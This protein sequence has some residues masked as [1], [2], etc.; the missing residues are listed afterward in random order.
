MSAAAQTALAAAAEDHWRVLPAVAFA[1][2]VGAVSV[3][4]GVLDY[5]M[6]R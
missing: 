6:P 5:T 1:L 2:G 4:R 3:Y